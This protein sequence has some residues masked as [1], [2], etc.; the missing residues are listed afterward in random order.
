MPLSPSSRGGQQQGSGRP[1]MDTNHAYG[2]IILIALVILVALR[3]AFGSIR[4][5]MGAH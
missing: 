1:K 5:E 3:Y 2:L 4:V